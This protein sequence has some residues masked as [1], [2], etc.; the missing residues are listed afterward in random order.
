MKQPLA[1]MV[2]AIA[3]ACWDNILVWLVQHDAD[4]SLLHMLWLRMLFMALCLTTISVFSPRQTHHFSIKWWLTF[5][6]IG[7]VIPTCTYSMSVLWT[8]YRLSLS[9]Q[10]FIPLLVAIR[11][12]STFGMREC[13]SL[14]MTMV[15]TWVLWS[16]IIWKHEFWMI[17]SAL[18]ASMIHAI[19]LVEW[20]VM[21]NQIPESPLPYMARAAQ[22]G[23]LLMF[24][25]TIVW[26]PQHLAGVFVYET[27]TWLA[28]IIAAAIASSC[29]YWMVAK[30]TRTMTPAAVAI[31]ECVHPIATLCSDI[32]R[33][34]D[35]L[36]WQDAFAITLYTIGWILYPK[37]N[38]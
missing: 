17:W 2:S 33:G 4:A 21:L 15:A 32:I 1:L 24:C 25:M 35:K 29:K 36:E 26:T 14:I 12:R 9:F 28:I 30:F 13:F 6:I 11:T 20:F 38:I 22:L 34:N 27:N 16:T 5:S 18:L 23:V 10:P 3:H 8:G 37:H 19:C 31:F 7:W